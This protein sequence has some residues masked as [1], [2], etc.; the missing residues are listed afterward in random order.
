MIND[1][2]IN[3]LAPA[4]RDMAMVFQQYA[5]YPH[6]TVYYNMAYGLK[7]RGYSKEHIKSRIDDVA[8]LLQLQNYLHR[9]P[10][11]LSGGQKQRV[12]MGGLL[13]VR[14]LCSYSTNHYQI[15]MLNYVPK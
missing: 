6:M 12:A 11:T 9:K 4:D 7:I 8:T 15:W 13:C 10:S 2:C 14:H 3:T 5:L 1:Q